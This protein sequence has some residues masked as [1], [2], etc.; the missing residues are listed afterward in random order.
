MKSTKG[1]LKVFLRAKIEIIND[2]SYV[3]LIYYVEN[4]NADEAVTFSLGSAADTCVGND[5]HAAVRRSDDGIL[6]LGRDY[7]SDNR[8]EY[9]LAFSVTN[10]EESDADVDRWWYGRYYDRTENIFTGELPTEELNGVDSGMAYSWIDQ[11]LEG[12]QTA[13]YSVLFGIGSIEDYAEPEQKPEPE[14]EPIPTP[15]PA[16]SDQESSYES[17]DSEDH[18]DT[19]YWAVR[20]GKWTFTN[21][22]SYRNQWGY[23]YY[24]GAYGWYFFNQDGFMETGWHTDQDGRKFYL[25]PFIDGKQGMMCTGWNLIDGKWYYFSMEDGA[26]MGQ[27]LVSATT[28][29][30]YEVDENGEW[31]N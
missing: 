5:D 6:M 26:G 12:G 25:N 18:D 2:L 13:K 9:K 23:L 31:I 14:P 4:T 29:D 1:D 27:L 24:N 28:P 15:T 19:E 11:T 10:D 20:D 16:P 8:E 3:R 30:G 17:E 21:G 22:V 7:S